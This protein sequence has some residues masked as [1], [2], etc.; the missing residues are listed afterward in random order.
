MGESLKSAKRLMK[1]QTL[2]FIPAFVLG[3][4]LGPN[5]LSLFIAV[6]LIYQIGIKLKMANQCTIGIVA[7]IFI[8][9]SPPEAFLRT[10]LIR[11]FGVMMGLGIAIIINRLVWPP[12]YRAAMV[13][14]A[15]QLNEMVT[16]YFRQSVQAYLDNR[17]MDYKERKRI[18]TMLVN[19][20]R[21][22]DKNY[23]Y[24]CSE[25]IQFSDPDRF[26]EETE[27]EKEQHFFEA[28][29]D[30]CRNLIILTKD[31][32]ALADEQS[33]RL[34]RWKNQET[35]PV[36]PRIPQ[37]I[38]EA[39]DRLEECNQELFGKLTGAD[40]QPF[41]DPHIWERMD[42]LL[43]E[44]HNT[45]EQNRTNLHSLVELSLVT[46]HIRWTIKGV[47]NMLIMEPCH[48]PELPREY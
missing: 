13:R 6:I 30:F 10:A 1:L 48:M 38:T 46:Y 22:F 2:A 34:K 41:K 37:L 40:P 43:T 31:N 19:E 44:W 3:L 39:L 36:D 27:E 25:R 16:R 14:Q 26:G 12:Q 29:A 11:S 4:T 17:P 35:N 28:Y 23:N 20:F 8:L 33:Q 21:S 45:A 5:I 15:I 9:T 42:Q 18:S 47:L 32:W 7:A 24:F